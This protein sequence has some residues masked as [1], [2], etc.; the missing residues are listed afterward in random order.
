MLVKLIAG[1]ILAGLI[2]GAA[3]R[4]RS[5]NQS[6][7]WA[8]L[9]LGTIIFGM[10][11]L[12]WAIALL[13]FFVSSSLLSRAGRQRK[14]TLEEKY[15]KGH[16]RDAWQVLA[17]GGLA[18]GM[19]LLH[20]FMPHSP[21]PWV[22]FIA[23]LAAANADTW[24]TELGSLS[25]SAP[26]LITSLRPVERGTSGGISPLGMLAAL[27]G[28]ALL[29]VVGVIFWNG[30]ILPIPA[31]VP[32]TLVDLL[33]GVPVLPPPGGREIW[34]VIFTLSGWIG[35]LVDSLL[36]ATVQAIY[37]CPACE[38]ETEQHPYHTCGAHTH[39]LRGWTWMNNDMVNLICTV[40]AAI[41]AVLFL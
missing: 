9:I 10:G 17:N 12:A 14:K 18:G 3:Y 34:L 13:A 5:L 38:K 33:G 32:F 24:A 1:I 22:G 20:A 16:Q 31:G 30:F 15:S 19:A 40:S 36:G 21:L 25:P 37:W 26:R 2:S 27:A 29:A 4:V 35:S 39:S 23:A 41:F 11:G 7:F 28:A 6:G 8:A